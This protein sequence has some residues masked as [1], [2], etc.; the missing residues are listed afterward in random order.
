MDSTTNLEARR[1]RRRN[2]QQQALPQ[3]QA[4]YKEFHQRF[5]QTFFREPEKISPLKKG[6]HHELN[7]VYADSPYN[8]RVIRWTLNRYVRRHAYVRAL[9]AGAACFRN[10]S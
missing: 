5:P 2:Q 6:M 9:A 1:R 10:D 3:I 7:A 8:T 4:L